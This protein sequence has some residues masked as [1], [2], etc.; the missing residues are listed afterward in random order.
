MQKGIQAMVDAAR[1][2]HGKV[3]AV[4]DFFCSQSLDRTGLARGQVLR[5]QVEDEVF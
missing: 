5:E 3:L 2:P 1:L 4:E